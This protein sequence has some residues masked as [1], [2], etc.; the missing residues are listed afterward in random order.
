MIRIE[1]DSLP[2]LLLPTCSWSDQAVCQLHDRP[3]S[4]VPALS[5]LREVALGGDVLQATRVRIC[6]D[7]TRLY[8]RFDC[9][10]RDIWSTYTRRDEPLYNEEVVEVFIASG[11]ATPR[12]YYEFE[13]NPLGA[14]FDAAID[15]PTGSRRDFRVDPAWDCVGIETE[16]RIAP[17]NGS[18][19][20][21]FSIPW[22]SISETFGAEGAARWRLNF[23]RIERPRNAAP[24][25]SAW[26][27]T[28][29]VP[30]DFHCPA[31]FGTLRR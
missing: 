5:P 13:L 14:L 28:F 16:V 19:S 20:A 23:Y 30:A 26:S 3:W 8:V 7:D 15:N 17:E 1:P 4:S 2:E 11:A 29:A 25:F 31:W 27:P 9:A 12:R 22:A 24:E 6:G 10:D 18:W 21:I